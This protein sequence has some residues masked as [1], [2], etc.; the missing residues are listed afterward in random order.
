MHGIIRIF[1]SPFT[2]RITR[3]TPSLLSRRS[4]GVTQ[5]SKAYEVIT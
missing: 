5:C 3:D 2:E 1:R 4:I